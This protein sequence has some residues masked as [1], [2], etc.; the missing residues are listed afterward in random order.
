MR[1]HRFEWHVTDREYEADSWNKRLEELKAYKEA[2]GNALVSRN[3]EENKKLGRWC[4]HQRQQYRNMKAGKR[5]YMTKEKL[6]KL[7]DAGFV[8]VPPPQNVDQWTVNYNKLAK[9]KEENGNCRVPYSYPEDPGLGTWVETLRTQY[10]RLKRGRSS[11][12]TNE[13]IRMLEDLGMEWE[14]KKAPSAAVADDGHSPA[15]QKPTGRGSWETRFEELKAYKEVHGHANV[16]NNYPPNKRLG[17]FVKKQRE[18]YRLYNSGKHSAMSP[19]RIERLE[20]LGFAWTVTNREY[21]HDSW[22]RRFQ[23]LKEFKAHFGHCFVPRQYPENQKLAYWVERQRQD[24]RNLQKGKPS[25]MTTDRVGV[26]EAAGFHWSP[27][28][29]KEL[30]IP[31]V[32]TAARGAAVSLSPQDPP[33]LPGTEE[34]TDADVAG[35]ITEA[36]AHAEANLN[37]KEM[38]SV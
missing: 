1:L 27:K 34:V 3:Y 24:Y 36:V 8:F 29:Q 5:H 31:P 13:R 30:G 2:N 18:D 25:K 14:V 33:A 17:S 22:A 23:E 19:E 28:E 7:E 4:D 12:L 11:R 21:Y 26:L 16:P 9:Y 35:A 6:K 37:E 38:A 20:S 32:P 10:T 15:P